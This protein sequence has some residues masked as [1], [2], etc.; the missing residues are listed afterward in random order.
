VA[1]ML[2]ARIVAGDARLFA[3]IRETLFGFGE[4]EVWMHHF[5]APALEFQT[6]LRLFSGLLGRSAPVDVKK[7]GIFPVV[8]GVR[9]LALKHRLAEASTFERIDALMDS[10]A[11]SATLGADLRQA[12]AIMLRLR[13]GQ[14]IEAVSEGEV[15][16]NTVQLDALRRLDR[17][18]LRDAFGVVREFQRSLSSRFGHGL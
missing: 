11:L 3:S 9:T 1:I 8:H 14:Q 7:G 5:V 18:L 17:D 6:P 15:P 4:N 10:G 13:L 12:Y 2:D 16:G